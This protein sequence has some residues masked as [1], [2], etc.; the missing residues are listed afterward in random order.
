MSDYD[1]QYRAPEALEKLRD[2]I[3]TVKGKYP[4]SPPILPS[5]LSLT[6]GGFKNRWHHACANFMCSVEYKRKDVD[7]Q[8]RALKAIKRLSEHIATNEEG[9][10][11]PTGKSKSVKW[12]R[13]PGPDG[14]QHPH[15]TESS[16]M[17]SATS[18]DGAAGRFAVSFGLG[19]LLQVSYTG[20]NK[21]SIGL[22]VSHR[23]RTCKKEG[24]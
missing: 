8:L 23:H 12:H 21:P 11:L 24:L 3:D 20:P 15:F 7:S 22:L 9:W 2:I 13:A 16:I 1:F 5:F 6:Y 10:E 4:Q 18:D 17:D 14:T 19:S